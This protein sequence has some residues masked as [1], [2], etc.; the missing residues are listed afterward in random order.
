M[1]CEKPMVVGRRGMVGEVAERNEQVGLVH[2]DIWNKTSL[3]ITSLGNNGLL[4]P[5]L[6]RFPYRKKTSNNSKNVLE[7]VTIATAV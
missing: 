4:V 6:L 5:W 2:G 3:C 7:M 1:L